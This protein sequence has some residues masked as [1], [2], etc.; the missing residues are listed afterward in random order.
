MDDK[1]IIRF[2]SK[3]RCSKTNEKLSSN[4]HYNRSSHRNC[5]VK[6]GAL[7]NFANFTEKTPLLES[8]FYK[9]AGS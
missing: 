4:I 6:K 7:K 5:S 9:V 1:K 3:G 2:V 8:L